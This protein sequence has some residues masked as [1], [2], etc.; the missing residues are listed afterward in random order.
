MSS[1]FQKIRAVTIHPHPSFAQFHVPLQDLRQIF[2]G[3]TRN[4][5]IGQDIGILQKHLVGLAA[6]GRWKNRAD[7]GVRNRNLVSRA[8]RGPFCGC[9]PKSIT[10]MVMTKAANI[11]SNVARR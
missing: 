9:W 3:D 8:C 11:A 6:V 1:S 2:F 10:G 7:R 5:V 4:L